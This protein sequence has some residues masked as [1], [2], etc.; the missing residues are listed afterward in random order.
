VSIPS[1]ASSKLFALCLCACFIS[2]SVG[3]VYSAANI[4]GLFSIWLESLSWSSLP[5]AYFWTVLLF[6]SIVIGAF[7]SKDPRREL[8][9]LLT[10]LYALEVDITYSFSLWLNFNGQGSSAKSMR[11]ILKATGCMPVIWTKRLTLRKFY[12][13]YPRTCTSSVLRWLTSAII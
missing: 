10:I 5:F 8:F 6:E 4:P 12:L 11:L 3:H 1:S 2:S 9:L 13:I 7:S